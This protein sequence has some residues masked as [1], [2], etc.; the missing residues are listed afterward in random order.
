MKQR[1]VQPFK[2]NQML[3]DSGLETGIQPHVLC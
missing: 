1:F 3:I 2:R